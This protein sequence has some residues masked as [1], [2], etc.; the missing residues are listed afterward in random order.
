MLDDVSVHSK[1]T[2]RIS[3]SFAVLKSRQKHVDILT[4]TLEHNI[5]WTVDEGRERASVDG[6]THCDN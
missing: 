3:F 5:T 4:E 2:K 1:E 6:M